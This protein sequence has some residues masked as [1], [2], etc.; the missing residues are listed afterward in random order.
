MYIIKSRGVDEAPLRFAIKQVG[1]RVSV[2]AVIHFLVKIFLES[3]SMDK[4]EFYLSRSFT[5]DFKTK[6]LETDLSYKY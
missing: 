4:R 3:Q 2:I 1:G 6:I 5:S